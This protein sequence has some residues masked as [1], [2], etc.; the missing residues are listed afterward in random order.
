[1]IKRKNQTH[2]RKK[3]LNTE[4]IKDSQKSKFSIGGEL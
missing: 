1:M 2:E 4:R 3:E